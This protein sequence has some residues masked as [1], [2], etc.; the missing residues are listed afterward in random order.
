MGVSEKNF[1][2]DS[3]S[4]AGFIEALHEWVKLD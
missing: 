1:R 4:A 3:E 2:F